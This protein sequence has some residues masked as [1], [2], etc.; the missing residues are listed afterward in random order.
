MNK[1]LLLR[2]NRESGPHSLKEISSIGLRPLD[3]I[4]IEDIS[5]A[6]KYPDEIEELRLLIK[7]DDDLSPSKQN[8]HLNKNEKVFV[9]LPGNFHQRNKYRT[10]DEYCRLPVNENEPV[11]ETNYAKPLDEIKENYREYK[12]QKPVWNKK[13][14]SSSHSASV[15]AIFFGVMLTAFI[16]KNLVDGYVPDTKEE[17]VAATPVIDRETEKPV[18]ENFKNAL[19]T[20]IVPVYKNVAPKTKPVN[21]K[22][23]LKLKSNEYKVGLFGG[24]NGLQLTVFNT[25]PHFVDRVLV[26]LDYLR[27]NGVVVQSENILFSSIKAKGAQTITIPGSNRGV[28]VR[29]KIL[30]VY[31]HDY[32]NALKQV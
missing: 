14:F 28:K 23:Q 9:S 2:D 8:H 6:W 13:I 1:Y 30:K 21:I 5:T 32:Q 26:A 29:Y 17:A 3:L 12:Q 11:L 7:Y 27:P 31:S 10:E 16:I 19:S 4:W 15:A 24:I 20:E 22:Q 25:S 18:T